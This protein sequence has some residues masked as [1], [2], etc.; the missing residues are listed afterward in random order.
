[1]KLPREKII[2]D[3][4]N[5]LTDSELLAIMLSSGTKEED[6]FK[7]SER[8][9]KDF[10]FSGLINMNYNELSKIQGIKMAKAS[11]LMA[12]F[13]I[14]RRVM[15]EEKEKK[16]II[17]AKSLYEYVYPY[18]YGIKKELLIVIGVDSKLRI[19]K[20]K[21]YTS[22]SY[23][24]INVPLK[25]LIKDIISMDPYGIF[26]IHNHPAGNVNP[27]S[28]DIKY[29]VDLGK[30][31]RNIDI[32]LLDHLII[33]YDKYYSFSDSKCLSNLNYWFIYS[34]NL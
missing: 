6:V 14:A 20:E 31:L 17:D 23:N 18:Y 33:S 1:M 21:K 34:Y 24:E 25:E 32:L 26:L 7:M 13:E 4:P 8:L 9:I 11:K 27:S 16:E 15:A 2:E 29:T 3:G 28:S 22:D 19:I 10:G 12:I 5:T 30:T